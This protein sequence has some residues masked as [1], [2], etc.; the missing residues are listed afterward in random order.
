MLADQDMV[1][2][3]KFYSFY[4]SAAI[5]DTMEWTTKFLRSKPCTRLLLYLSLAGF[6]YGFSLLNS[7]VAYA[8]EDEE[9]SVSGNSGRHK[10]FGFSGQRLRMRKAGSSQILETRVDFLETRSE[11][12]QKQMR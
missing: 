5:R 1:A 8:G 10:G 7:S 11:L 3:R 12:L 4:V 6:V 9:N 2:R